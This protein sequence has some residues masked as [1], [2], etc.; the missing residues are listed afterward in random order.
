ME[1]VFRS[2]IRENT[3]NAHARSGIGAP[4]EFAVGV[5]AP[6]PLPRMSAKSEGGAGAGADG[7][8]GLAKSA[9]RGGASE[10]I[11]APAGWISIRFQK[12]ESAAWD[13]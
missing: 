4:D 10:A 13:W 2:V 7:G 9:G 12:L 6:P 8:G 3:Y 11:L 1:I 5:G